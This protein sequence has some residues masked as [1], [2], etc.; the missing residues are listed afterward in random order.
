SI[1]LPRAQAQNLLR[2]PGAKVLTSIAKEANFVIAGEDAGQKLA[3]AQ[4]L[5]LGILNE[6]QFNVLLK[7][8]TLK[9]LAEKEIAQKAKFLNEIFEL[10]N[11]K[12]SLFS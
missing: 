11:S 2:R 4:A 8:E 1:S 5:G 6:E 12:S 10:N 3:K 9:N 7:E